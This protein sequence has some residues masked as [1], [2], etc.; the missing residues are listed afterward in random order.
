MKCSTTRV[1]VTMLIVHRGAQGLQI[2]QSEIDDKACQ[3]IGSFPYVG[4]LFVEDPPLILIRNYAWWRN[5][6]FKGSHIFGP[7]MSMS[8][9]VFWPKVSIVFAALDQK[10]ARPV[11]DVPQQARLTRHNYSFGTQCRSLEQRQIGSLSDSS[12]EKSVQSASFVFHRRDVSCVTAR[13]H[14]VKQRSH[15]GSCCRQ[16]TMPSLTW[17][18]IAMSSSS[19]KPNGSEVDLS[20]CYQELG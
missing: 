13:E 19:R 3:F 14:S 1:A 9:E 18:R 12:T 15:S 16:S 8:R 6:S 11:S 2:D 20:T 5:A 17:S 7:K 10:A 4:I